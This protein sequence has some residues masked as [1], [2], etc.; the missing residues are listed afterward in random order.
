MNPL[1]LDWPQSAGAPLE[2]AKKG[3]D[4]VKLIMAGTHHLESWLIENRILP[5]L[6]AHGLGTLRF[7]TTLYEQQKRSA[8]LL[9]LPDGTAFACDTDGLW[10]ALQAHEARYEIEHIGSRFA[11]GDHW[12]HSFTALL[13]QADEVTIPIPPL[14]VA[15]HWETVTGARPDGFEVGTLDHVEAYGLGVAEKFLHT[16]SRL[17]F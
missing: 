16:R 4:L 8:S 12:L 2:Q 9:P 11:P 7:E 1:S 5:V 15:R 10:S 14:D 13:Q 17:G 6:Q 3:A